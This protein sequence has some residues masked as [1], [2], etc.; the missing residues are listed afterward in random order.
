M[1]AA[2][3]AEKVLKAVCAE[4]EMPVS[5]LKGRTRGKRVVAA[6]HMFFYIMWYK[7]NHTKLGRMLNKCHTLVNY[8]H[9]VMESKLS[10]WSEH[11]RHYQ[12]IIDALK[13]EDKANEGA[14]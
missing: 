8:G 14:A 11:R 1:N 3:N 9:E 10:I 12:R 2:M 13:D 6:R 4:Y 7:D 5:S